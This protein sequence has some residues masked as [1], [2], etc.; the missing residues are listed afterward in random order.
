MSV[1]P[2]I[3]MHTEVFPKTYN[4]NHEMHLTE[5]IKTS[6]QKKANVYIV[7]REIMPPASAWPPQMCPT[8]SL[9]C[10]PLQDWGVSET[11]RHEP[12]GDKPQE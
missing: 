5:F 6:L 9:L 8:L 7:S 11:P 1:L 4:E 2:H 10:A 12:P 3:C